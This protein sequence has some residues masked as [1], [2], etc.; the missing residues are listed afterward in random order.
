MATKKLKPGD[1]YDG[2]KAIATIDGI[3]AFYAETKNGPVRLVHVDL[4]PDNL[5]GGSEEFRVAGPDDPH[6][7]P[8]S[9]VDLLPDVIH[10]QA[11]SEV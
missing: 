6:Q 1:L 8:T 3:T 9:F 7:E 2:P 11:S 4:E 10:G 5:D